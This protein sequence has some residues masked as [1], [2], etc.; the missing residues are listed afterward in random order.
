M[1]VLRLPAALSVLLA[2]PLAAQGD[3]RIVE[4]T[5]SPDIVY[6][7]SI[8]PDHASVVEL[9]QDEV[10]ESIVVGSADG[11]MVEPTASADRVVV[12][13]L[14][15]AQRTNMTVLT[16]RRSYA[17]TLDPGGG[18]DM[19]ILRFNYLQQ[20]GHP[21]RGAEVT[22]RFRGDR[23]LYP[24]LMT[25]NGSTTS[26]FWESGQAFPAVFILDRNGEEVAASYRAAGD[27]LV[28]DGVHDQIVFRH[29][30]EKAR[31]HRIGGDR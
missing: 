19:Y 22:Y 4:Q 24:R 8:S 10:V 12:K 27:G 13:P 26:I 30:E 21:G 16:T 5:Y 28:V 7:L 29:G 25:D 3:P 17:F 15:G 14:P 1:K 2:S 9:E 20:A 31:A 6:A 23:A 18:I 11:W